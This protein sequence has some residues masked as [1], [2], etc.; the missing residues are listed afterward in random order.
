MANILCHLRCIFEEAGVV[1]QYDQS[2][3]CLF[4]DDHELVGGEGPPDV[5]FSETAV[6][7]VEDARIA[8]RDVEDLETLKFL[9]VLVKGN[10]PAPQQELRGTLKEW[11]TRER[12]LQFKFHN[13]LL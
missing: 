5:K 13:Q 7:S 4:Q 10:L 8:P 1:F 11:G 6:E 2:L 9:Q 12:G 3:V